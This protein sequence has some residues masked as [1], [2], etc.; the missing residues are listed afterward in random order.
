MSDRIEIIKADLSDSRRGAALI[1][2]LDHYMRDPMEGGEPPSERVKRDLIPALSAHPA[3]WVLFALEEGRPVG[4]AI[5]FVVFSTFNA[6]PIVNIHDL[7][8]ESCLRGSGIGK[9]LIEGVLSRAREINACALT[10]EVRQDNH[11]ARGLYRRY[12]FARADVAGRV[13]MEFWRKPLL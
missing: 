6:R 8:V 9:R 2:M 12:G 7:F 10:L 5:C 3:C 13:P 4:F 11:R 1:E